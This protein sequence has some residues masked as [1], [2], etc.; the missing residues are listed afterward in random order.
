ME[1]FLS[2]AARS[3]SPD[4]GGLHIKRLGLW[5]EMCQ[6][7][8]RCSLCDAVVSLLQET[9]LETYMLEIPNIQMKEIECTLNRQDHVYKH[10]NRQY[11]QYDSRGYYARIAITMDIPSR[12]GKLVTSR[13]PS[14]LHPE[15]A[16]KMF[17]SRPLLN[18][19]SIGGIPSYVTLSWVW[20]KTSAQDG[21]T[22]ACLADASEM[23]FL[24]RLHLPLTVIDS[25]KLLKGLGERFLWVD[26]L[27]I[28]QDDKG[29]KEYFM[30]RMGSI[31]STSLFTI[32]ANGKDGAQEGLPGV[33]PSGRR[34]SQVDTEAHGITLV[35]C[36]EPTWTSLEHVAP[37]DVQNE[38]FGDE[39]PPP[40][41]HDLME[42]SNYYEEFHRHFAA[43]I[44][45]HNGRTL[46]FESDVLHAFEGILYTLRLC[47]GISF[48]WGLPSC[49]FEQSLLWNVDG[50]FPIRRKLHHVPTWSWLHHRY[51]KAVEK[52]IIR[53]AAA[54]RC[55]C[56]SKIS[57]PDN[58]DDFQL[59]Q[60]SGEPQCPR[61]MD[62]KIYNSPQVRS[63]AVE[64]IDPWIRY[65]IKPAYHLIFWAD[66][67]AAR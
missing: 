67:V 64:D 36:V 30:P 5:L 22:S 25:L 53:N 32:I 62:H 8:K 51:A 12:L 37:L 10:R 4:H 39:A 13:E 20:G 44:L 52:T 3:T 66:T 28:V 33:R 24:E 58:E 9:G 49:L 14:S 56:R 11:G 47:T 61:E 7:R 19:K 50:K 35:S 65:I 55:F 6:L 42:L 16:H 15:A 1:N 54:V 23:N 63:V 26:M 18:F 27:C 2:S 17:K 38:V 48:L 34:R 21:L 29:D 57:P 31:Y 60:V 46:F 45:Q 59:Q 40:F 41:E 43:I